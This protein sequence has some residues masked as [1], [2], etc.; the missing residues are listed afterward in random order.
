MTETSA[1]SRNARGAWRPPD[2]QGSAPIWAW[3]PQ[4]LKT[5]K[6]VVGNPGYLFP[7]YA[8]YFVIAAATW[9]YLT[10]EMARMVEFRAAWIA[11]IYVRNLGLLVLWAGGWHVRLYR[12]KSQGAEYKF[13]PQWLQ[14]KSATFLWGS[15]LRDNVFWSIASGCTVWTAYEVVMMWGYANG[16]IAWVDWR[17]E[18]V[19]FALMVLA[20]PL[21]RELHFYWTHRLIHWKP[22]YRTVHYL[23]HKNINVGPWTGLANHPGEHIIYFSVA[24][25]FWIVPSH[26]LMVLLTLQDAALS[27]APGHSGFDKHV[28]KGKH[29]LPGSFFHYL[30]HRYF[31][32]NYGNPMIP[33]DKWLGTQHDGSPEAHARMHARW[34][35][36]RA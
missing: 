31:E 10:P 8:I 11:E 33:F 22:L 36:K 6:W 32:C 29:T 23:H 18:P 26:P 35:E 30:H 34:G 16:F 24:L 12:F 4:P 7:W 5:L 1:D 9:A 20:I 19:T 13:S 28:V 17:T 27:G 25:L 15:Q 3:P 21:W 2:F 14:G